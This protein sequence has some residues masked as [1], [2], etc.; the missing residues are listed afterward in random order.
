MIFKYLNP[1]DREAAAL[2]CH[3][4]FLAAQ[5]Y[6]FRNDVTLHLNEI[7]FAEH[8]L[9]ISHLLDSA[10][11]YL[12]ISLTKVRFGGT[13]EFW[14]MF[15]PLVNSLTINS[16]IMAKNKFLSIIKYSTRLK[17]LTLENC[18]DL[19]KNWKTGRPGKEN[20]STVMKHLKFLSLA[21]N[22]H[23]TEEIF[24]YLVQLAPNLEQLDLSQSFLSMEAARRR[25]SLLNILQYISENARKIKGLNFSGTPLEDSIL[26]QLSETNNLKLTS[27]SMTFAGKET[28]P[29]IINLFHY[30]NSITFLDLSSSLSLTDFCLT[31][32]CSSMKD[33][34]VLILKKCWMLTDYGVQE[35]E[36]LTKLE[37]K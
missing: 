24:N 26:F 1:S 10:T 25:S 12:N 20:I 35:I 4:W 33:L 22:V 11:S 5:Y 30:Q 37:V 9:P 31:K 15:G 6:G 19:F 8:A 2:T 7:Q 16:G 13:N 36:K 23:L 18:N 32:I 28:N 3:Q 34:K 21:N 27:L 29:G 14:L 17:R